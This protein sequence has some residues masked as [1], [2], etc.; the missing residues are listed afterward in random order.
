MGRV[1]SFSELADSAKQVARERLRD[2]LERLPWQARAIRKI[3]PT[4]AESGILIDV[5]DVC[6][7]PDGYVSFTAKEVKLDIVLAR[8][9]VG[10]KYLANPVYHDLFCANAKAFVKRV[11]PFSEVTRMV[12]ISVEID[13]FDNN[14]SGKAFL[15][16]G[17]AAGLLEQYLKHLV[18]TISDCFRAAIDE[19]CARIFSPSFMDRYLESQGKV[20]GKNGSIIIPISMTEEKL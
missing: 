8:S 15:V 18:S 17:I 16:C 13:P 9:G 4:V 6:V 7:A 19:E 2:E 12:S 11:R 3:L 14:D 10:K 5:Q 20:F 1:F